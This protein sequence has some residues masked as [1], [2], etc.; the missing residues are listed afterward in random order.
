MRPRIA[1]VVTTHSRPHL[2]T[3]AIDSVQ[4]QTH[5]VDEILVCEDGHDEATASI[6]ASVSRVDPRIRHLRLGSALRGPGSNRNQALAST[7]DWLAFLDDDDRWH[8]NRIARQIPLLDSAALI[9]SN[10]ERTSGGLYHPARR[11]R[12]PRRLQVLVDN[13]VIT[14][15][16]LLR[17]D[18][19][20]RIGGF[21]PDLRL[22]GIEDYECWLR[23]SD[24]GFRF[25]YIDEPLVVYDDSGSGRL[26]DRQV[27]LARTLAR[28]ALARTRN[29]PGDTGRWLG[30]ARYSASLGLTKARARITRTRSRETDRGPH[31]PP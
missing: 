16:V 17:R 21:S 15:S 13:P 22:T 10:A 3:R 23:I 5:P 8:P 24:E 28:L 6:V 30:L 11:P 25:K 19:L 2:L 26:S 4:Q 27:E 1:A 18:A 9:C 31:K 12:S 14:S 29:R 20:T 7:C